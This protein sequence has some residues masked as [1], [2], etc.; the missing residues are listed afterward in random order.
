MPRTTRQKHKAQAKT[1]EK[2]AA[3][4]KSKKEAVQAN[5]LRTRTSGFFVML[6]QQNGRP[7]L[8]TSTADPF[9][10]IPTAFDVAIFET[11]DE[12]HDAAGENLLG[13]AFGF[14]VFEW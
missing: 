7:A 10:D 6:G 9:N 5:P 3:A 12:A 11:E 1:Q 13:Q 8:M 4:R 2:R 14:Q